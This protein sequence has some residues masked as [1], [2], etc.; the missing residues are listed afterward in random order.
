MNTT[1]VDIVRIIDKNKAIAAFFA[2]FI[3]TLLGTLGN[4]IATGQFNADEIRIAGAGLIS[5]AAA[6]LAAYFAKAKTAEVKVPPSPIVAEVPN[7]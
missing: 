4:W 1:V 5:S 6:A 2:P 7:P 3:L